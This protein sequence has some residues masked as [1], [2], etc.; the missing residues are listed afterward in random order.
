MEKLHPLS[1]RQVLVQTR[2]SISFTSSK[3]E[4]VLCSRLSRSL[5]PAQPPS[6]PRY[7]KQEMS[8]LYPLNRPDD[9]CEDKIGK[10]QS[11]TSNT[12]WM[13]HYGDCA[14]TTTTTTTSNE[15]KMM[16]DPLPLPPAV[17][18]GWNKCPKLHLTSH[19]Q[20]KRKKI[21]LW[22]HSGLAYW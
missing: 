22:A 2:T 12:W 8:L 11:N 13:D 3:I 21:A 7:T 6:R 19:E 17:T 1:Y 5:S 14:T 15:T 4:S 9:R 20:Q 16:E 18:L 10:L